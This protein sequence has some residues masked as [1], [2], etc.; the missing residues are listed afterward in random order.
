MWERGIPFLAAG[1]LPKNAFYSSEQ[2]RYM[3]LRVNCEIFK[4]DM[5]IRTNGM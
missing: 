4:N 1:D 3:L 5:G 2:H